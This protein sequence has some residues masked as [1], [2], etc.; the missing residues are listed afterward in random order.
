IEMRC[1]G[2]HSPGAGG[3]PANFPLNNW[4]DLADN[5]KEERRSSGMSLTKLALTTHVH[6]L[7]FSMLY[8][9]TGLA[10]A[11]TSYPLWVRITIAP[12]ALLAQ[13]VDI[14][15]W[16]LARLDDPMGPMFARLITVSGG[17]VALG[18]LLQIVMTLFDLFHRMG[19]LVL[20]VLI[21]AVAGGGSWLGL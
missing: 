10:L 19:R 8:G 3:A 20:V 15:F 16:W 13:I 18:L 21:L 14:S 17:V 1:V 2:C 12:L 7:G 5:L 4:E 9:L 11:F 6:L